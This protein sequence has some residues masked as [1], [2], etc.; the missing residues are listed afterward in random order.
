[1][2]RFIASYRNQKWLELVLDCVQYLTHEPKKQQALGKH[3]YDDS[4]ITEFLPVRN[5]SKGKKLALTGSFLN[6]T[7]PLRK[8]Y[9]KV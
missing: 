5:W 1:M 8:S 6:E 7:I 9:T 4:E 2:V 3:H